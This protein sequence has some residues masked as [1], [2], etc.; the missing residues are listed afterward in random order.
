MPT[1]DLATVEVF[2]FDPNVDSEPRYSSFRVS[3]KSY[4]VMNVLSY[5]YENLDNTYSFRWACGKGFCRC[6]VLCVNGKP[7][8]ACMEPA[9]EYMKIEPH[10]KY[11]VLKD[12]LID[13]DRLK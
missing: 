10:P 5:I 9:S 6:C 13:F 3:Y 4:T 7:V 8:L 2:R 1:D 12:L 11:Q